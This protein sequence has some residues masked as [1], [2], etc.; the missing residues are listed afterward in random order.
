MAC[1]LAVRNPS[2]SSRGVRESLV[3]DAM[4]TSQILIGFHGRGPRKVFWLCG[5]PGWEASDQ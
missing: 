1:D 2:S 3:D 5:V 4:S